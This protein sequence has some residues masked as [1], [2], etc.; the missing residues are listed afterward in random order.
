MDIGYSYFD[1][2]D[3]CA[4]QDQK[5]QTLTI[6]VWDES[7]EGRRSLMSFKNIEKIKD[8]F[9]KTGKRKSIDICVQNFGYNTKVVLLCWWLSQVHLV[10]TRAVALGTNN[11]CIGVYEIFFVGLWESVFS[12]IVQIYC[13]KSRL[14]ALI[15]KSMS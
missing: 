7:K 15:I 4:K 9:S 14:L 3:G 8:T 2:V 5:S 1:K 13:R 10:F 11:K 6:Y 12:A